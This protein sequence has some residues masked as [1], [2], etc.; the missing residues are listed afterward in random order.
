MRI[1]WL[2]LL[3][4]LRIQAAEVYTE[5][6]NQALEWPGGRAAWG[7]HHVWLEERSAVCPEEQGFPV[8]V[9]GVLPVQGGSWVALADGRLTT[10]GAREPRTWQVERACWAVAATEAEDAWI[11]G[12][13]GLRRLALHGPSSPEILEC[14]ALPSLRAPRELC[15]EQGRPWLRLGD[16]LWRLSGGELRWAGRFPQNGRGWALRAGRPLG[17]DAAGRLHWLDLWDSGAADLAEDPGVE[18]GL[19]RWRRLLARGEDL[20][21]QAEDG[22]WWSWPREEARPRLCRLTAGTG[23]DWLPVGPELLLRQDGNSRSWWRCREGRWQAE[24]TLAREPA[25]LDRLQRWTSSWRLLRDGSLERWTEGRWTPS[26]QVSQARSLQPAGAGPLLVDGRGV[27][28]FA[29]EGPCL[30]MWEAHDLW[31]AA[32]LEDQLLVAGGDAVSSLNTEDGLPQLQ[33]QLALAE[34]TQ[35]SASPLWAAVL[36]EG[37]IWLLDRSRPHEPRRVDQRPV[38]AGLSSFLLQED[39]LYLLFPDH[40]SGWSCGAGR[41]EDARFD[42]VLPGARWACLRGANRLL[43][44]DEAGWLRQYLLWDNLPVR[45]EWSCELPIVGP[46]RVARDSLRV[47]GEA[48]WLDWPLPVLRLSWSAGGDPPASV[49][50]YDLLGRRL[51]HVAVR[52]GVAR[53]DMRSRAAGCYFLCEL[54][55]DGSLRAS[56]SLCWRP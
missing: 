34:A 31:A 5:A 25:L 30:G 27:W 14:L 26:L 50:L 35:L 45:E 53:L 36:A 23:V 1:T 54:G 7:G 52:F 49:V 8:G 44:L 51:E 43:T 55:P 33:H 19:P 39:R 47:T 21:L 2:A 38:P 48:G 29:D 6:W 32:P 20:W 24:Q 41:W 28:A 17:L 9:V 10:L 56:R 11:V 42:L 22:L 15:L 12:P 46:L 18:P 40:I 4:G 37:R 13:G 16:E 3:L